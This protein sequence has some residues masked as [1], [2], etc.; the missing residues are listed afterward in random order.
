[1]TQHRCDYSVLHD[2]K[3]RQPYCV[4]SIHPGESMSFPLNRSWSIFAVVFV[5]VTI[6][7]L[8][9]IFDG[10]GNDGDAWWLATAA[11][12]ISTTGEYRFS[13]PPGHPL[14]EIVSSY[15]WQYGPIGLNGATALL[16]ALGAGF[17]V[18]TLRE[19]G[20]KRSFLAGAA[21]ACTPVIWIHSVDAMDYVWALGFILA[22]FYAIVRK[23]TLVGGVLLAL[24]ISCRATSILMIIPLSVFVWQY[25]RTRAVFLFAL[26]S[27]L[28]GISTYYPAYK[29][30]GDY[31]FTIWEYGYPKLHTILYLLSVQVWGTIGVAT[32][33]WVL[34][35]WALRVRRIQTPIPLSRACI[36]ASTSGILVCVLTFLRLPHEP[37]YLIPI[38][39]F[40]ILLLHCLLGERVFAF[41][42]AGIV[43]SSLLSGLHQ[44]ERVAGSSVE[45]ASAIVF[46]VGNIELV[47]DLAYGPIIYE[48]IV[49]RARLELVDRVGE[50]S[51]RETDKV[52]FVVGGL[53]VPLNYLGYS[54][55]ENVVLT[56]VLTEAQAERYTAEGFEFYYLEDIIKRYSQAVTGLDLERIGANYIADHP[57]FST[58]E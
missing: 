6:T 54:G 25:G 20:S 53:N 57:H 9:F 56:A 12:A 21:L 16:S 11:R 37:G 31:V 36:I 5:I 42:C 58:F 22:S 10:Y 29:V 45:S 4:A 43:A 49:R 50:M 39:P 52:L 55:K 19:L 46:T 27:G 13:R 32:I 38:V 14:Q 41:A 33:L 34:A 2:R 30:H 18:L 28:L 48:S 51:R 15:L 17:F 8:P 7:R 35:H 3:I 1:M 40:G 47:W 24:A 44:R 26:T 23:Q